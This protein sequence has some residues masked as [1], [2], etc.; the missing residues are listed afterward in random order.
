MLGTKIWGKKREKAVIVSK[1]YVCIVL[2]SCNEGK[3]ERDGE[4]KET[5]GDDNGRV[6]ERERERERK[7]MK[8]LGTFAVP[9]IFIIFAK[10][11]LES[12]GIIN[13]NYSAI[14]LAGSG[15]V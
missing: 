12:T 13:L 3:R 5:S 7:M 8:L 4:R 14:L 11:P 1:R 10:N 9:R 15:G 2:R 6:R